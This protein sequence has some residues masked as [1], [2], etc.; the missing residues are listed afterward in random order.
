M[1]GINDVVK[2]A[3]LVHAKYADQDIRIRMQSTLTCDIFLMSNIP[4]IWHRSG[5]HS[6]FT[7]G[8]TECQYWALTIF[9][10]QHRFYQS[11]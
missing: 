9:Q 8:V 3:Y 4:D 7:V 11:Y 2:I 1:Q 6:E 10:C 5:S